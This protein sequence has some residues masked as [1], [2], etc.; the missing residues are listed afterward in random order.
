MGLHTFNNM[1]I[2]CSI[3]R[4]QPIISPFVIFIKSSE[5]LELKEITWMYLAWTDLPKDFHSPDT[6]RYTGLSYHLLP[7]LEI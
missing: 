3:V 5:S 6:I 1:H 2:T 7:Q 4:F